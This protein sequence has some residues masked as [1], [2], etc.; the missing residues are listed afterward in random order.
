MIYRAEN[1]SNYSRISN[2]VLRDNTL[3]DG[4]LRLLVYMLSM[5]DEWSFSAKALAQVFDVNECTIVARLTELKKHG[6]AKTRRLKDEQ[7][8]FSAC[9]W[10]VYEVPDTTPQ[11]E[12][13]TRGKNHTWKKPHVERTT[14]GK[15]QPLRT[16][17]NKEQSNIKEQSREKK[18]RAYKCPLGPF[19]NVLLT[20]E[21]QKD[22]TDRLGFDTVCGYIDRLSHYLHEHPEKNYPNHKATI[23]AWI[24]Q[25]ERRAA[26]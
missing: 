4:A 18:A 16:I 9:V 6:Y 10:D 11:T 13:T 2:A 12:K 15:T 8:R 25:D 22:L 5:S 24:N 19:E 23:E 26:N 3:S 21:E 1:K 17:N 7:G 14:R 20:N